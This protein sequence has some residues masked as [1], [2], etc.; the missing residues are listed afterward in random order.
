MAQGQCWAWLY[1]P[2]QTK[3]PGS[4]G[5]GG[6]AQS[7]TVCS[8]NKG[9]SGNTD[10]G[11]NKSSAAWSLAT[12]TSQAEYCQSGV[13]DL[14]PSHRTHKG[15]AVRPRGG[16]QAHNLPPVHVSGHSLW[17]SILSTAFSGGTQPATTPSLAGASG[18]LKATDTL[19]VAPGVPA[20]KRSI[21]EQILEGKF[22]DLAELPP[23]KSFS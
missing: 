4:A 7:S 9:P 14:A 2:M 19:V 23:A 13:T 22:I 17:V 12:A 5:L 21:V 8:I 16:G 11:H 1:V 20:L 18:S 6:R 3:L 15:Q 10:P